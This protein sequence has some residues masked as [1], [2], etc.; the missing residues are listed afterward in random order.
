MQR[1]FIKK[2]LLFILRSVFRVNR[3]N[4]GGKYFAH[5][6]EVETEVRKWLTQQSENF[7][8]SGFDAIV[9]QWDK[10]IEVGGGYVEE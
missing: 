1:I 2:C 10:C 6:E 7:Y 4:F 5:D 8:S 9:K 3:F